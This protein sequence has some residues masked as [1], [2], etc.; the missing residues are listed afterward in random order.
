MILI[1]R[2]S[3]RPFSSQ[4][5]VR[6][7]VE[8]LFFLA[9]TRQEF[10]SDEERDAWAQ[11]WLG[12]YWRHFL[13]WIY[14]ARAQDGQIVGYLTG[15]PDSPFIEKD[16]LPGMAVFSDLFERFPAHFHINCHPDWRSQGV[17]SALVAHYLKALRSEVVGVHIITSADARNRDF[18]RANG[19]TWE[20][21]RKGLVLM[22]ASF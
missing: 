9:S 22:G 18:Y 12:T 2:V 1:E 15:C 8:S 19:L 10:S 21:E 13:E 16:C 3:E 17:G 7:S 14:V 4:D 6:A 11:R 5:N 20:E